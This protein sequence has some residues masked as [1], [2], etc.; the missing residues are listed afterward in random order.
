MI[1]IMVVVAIVGIMG[2]TA[3][4]FYNVYRQKAY[5]AEASIMAKKLLEGQVAYFL[6][7]NRFFPDGGQ[8][9]SVYHDNPFS[10]NIEQIKEALHIAIPDDHRLD[11]QIY[12]S[13]ATSDDFCMIIVTAPFPLFKDGSPTIW[14]KADKSGE[15]FLSTDE[16]P[17]SEEEEETEE[18]INPFLEWLKKLFPWLF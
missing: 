18:D 5:S 17:E 3:K 12:T 16:V 7:N 10:D 11:Y 14:G 1:E 6:E 4:P 9:I 13:P 15:L 2:A 8:T